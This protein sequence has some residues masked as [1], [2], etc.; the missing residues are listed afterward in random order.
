M[1]VVRCNLQHCLQ[2]AHCPPVNPKACRLGLVELDTLVCGVC[3]KWQSPASMSWNICGSSAS[4]W[5]C[6]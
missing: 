2:Q 5:S 1:H 4:V 6:I 3:A